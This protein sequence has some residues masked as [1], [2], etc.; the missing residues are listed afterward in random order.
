MIYQQVSVP[1]TIC[2]RFQLVSSL[3]R[4]CA[5]YFRAARISVKYGCARKCRQE[6]RRKFCDER[7]HNS[8]TIHSLVNKLRRKGFSIEYKKHKPTVVT[9]EKL[10]DRGAG[11]QHT[12]RKL[13]KRLAQ[14]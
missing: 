10:D 5:A 3:A 4:H 2:S 9:E 1:L 7:V 11:L 6:F 12:P 13:L 14:S 8:E